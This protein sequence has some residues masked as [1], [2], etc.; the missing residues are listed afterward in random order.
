[1]RSNARQLLFEILLTRLWVRLLML[2]LALTATTLGLLGPFLQKT[3]LDRLSGSDR[4]STIHVS[5]ISNWTPTFLLLTSF[6]CLF[7]ALFLYQCVIYLGN[8]EALWMQRNLADRLYHHTLS[9]QT[10]SLHG[11][12]V[13]EIV[14][15]YTTDIPGATILLEQSL[16]Q[17]FGI[18]F[19]LLLGPWALI[20]FLEVPAHI[21]LPI[22]AVLLLINF[23]LAYRQSLFFFLFKQL[24]ADRVGLVNE[25]IQNIRILRILDWISQF[26]EKIFKVRK[27]ETRNRISM[28]NNGQTMNGIASSVTFI[29]NL[30]LI[31]SLIHYSPHQLSAGTLLA[32]LWIVAIFL[33][34]PF[35][36]LPW[37][38][39]FIFDGWTSLKRV[40]EI[41][42]LQNRIKDSKTE[43]Q[44]LTSGQA[45]KL[46]A[47]LDVKNLCLTSLHGIPLLK[48]ISFH[49]QRGEFLAI[50]GE[51]GSGKSLL[52]SSLM[53]Q[54]GAT[55]DHYFAC[56]QN[57]QTLTRAEQ[58]KFFSFVP[59]EG[60]IISASL[61]ENV[62][63][64]YETDSS[65]DPEYLASLKRAEFDL[66]AERTQAGL[67][68]EIG[69]RGV[70]LSGGQK[71]R[72]SLARVDL[73]DSPILLLD[74]CLSAVD[75][76]TEKK[77]IENLFLGAWK[78]RTR[79]L[80]THRLSV[81]KHVD[82]IL[83]LDHGALV[84]QGSFDE[85]QKNAQ[86]F[87]YTESLAL[88]EKKNQE[89]VTI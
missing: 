25:W 81:L 13:G 72:V 5:L 47:A 60:F 80:V 1:M 24:A 2:L 10:E 43:S 70:N 71:Q 4:F 41:L 40:A 85:L 73:R 3:F 44:N 76:D 7:G 48:N 78:T 34:R 32:M 29:L 28:L 14:S 17:G 64:Q 82:R 21:L 61:R 75:V 59:Q 57:T 27:I 87:L 12:A 79:L 49:V 51:V 53:G 67:D 45:P 62:A 33:T 8:K 77:L 20:H 31:W 89:A 50:V 36:Q 37:F 23:S 38:F 18:V 9:L 16:P 66:S 84:A 88:E 69:E 11:R 86:F 52:L 30:V 74:D 6:C 42:S 19:P 83:F 68:T 58:Q 55:T 54:T 15:I 65:Q 22:L 56:G 39:T 63:F 35:R 46:S 26:E